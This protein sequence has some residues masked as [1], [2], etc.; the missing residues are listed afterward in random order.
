MRRSNEQSL[1]DVLSRLVKRDGFRQPLWEAEIREIWM[2][3]M[4]EYIARNTSMIR[5]RGHVLELGI[6][7]AGLRNELHYSKNKI[8]SFLNEKLGQ[9]VIKEVV[10]RS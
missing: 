10:L 9:E 3:E 2:N 7:S 4:G 8:T 6:H 5:L 1:G